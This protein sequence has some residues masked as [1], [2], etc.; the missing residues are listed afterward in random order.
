MNILEC[1][2]EDLVWNAIESYDHKLLQKRGLPIYPYFE[3]VRQLTL[4]SYGRADIVG[5]YAEPS[6]VHDGKKIRNIHVQIIE[7]KK[8]TVGVD[9]LLQALR[10]AKGIQ[11]KA[12]IEKLHYTFHF[13]F[14][15]IGKRIDFNDELCYAPDL[16]SNVNIY[17]FALE[18]EKGIV[19]TPIKGYSLVN[20]SLSARTSDLKDIISS[21][22]KTNTDNERERLDVQRYY[23]EQER[24]PPVLSVV[25][26]S[27][28]IEEDLPF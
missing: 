6:F 5:F 23:E 25:R 11:H 7:L 15:L 27:T 20:H 4:G 16:L 2:I 10:Y 17:T 26:D 14:H 12:S 21:N 8:E 9:T 13:S 24:N 19:F 28:S 3:Y 18:L 22:V 1:E